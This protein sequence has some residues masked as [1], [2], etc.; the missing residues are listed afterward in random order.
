MARTRG[1][2]APAAF[3]AISETFSIFAA[4]DIAAIWRAGMPPVSGGVTAEQVAEYLNGAFTGAELAVRLAEA[5]APRH[6]RRAFYTAV[7]EHAGALLALLRSGDA[8][9]AEEGPSVMA[10][11]REAMIRPL[12]DAGPLTRQAFDDKLR[13]RGREASGPQPSPTGPAG[14]RTRRTRRPPRP[15]LDPMDAE[16]QV[17]DML[18][19]ALEGLELLVVLATVGVVETTPPPGGKRGG[20]DRPDSHL[21]SLMRGL[22]AAYFRATG[23]APDV[24][25]NVRGDRSGPAARWVDD[26]VHMAARKVRCAPGHVVPDA[27]AAERILRLQQLAAD[28]LARRLKEG[29]AEL[30]QT[31]VIKRPS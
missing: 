18:D 19:R 15:R 5:S 20:G 9:P 30:K 2:K 29:W 14:E 25:G 4:S 6:E 16:V 24:D 31:M 22:A 7:G 11:W 28:T 10:S 12:R 13:S 3:G 21:N 26:V 17:A 23:R 27:A 8:D 1:A